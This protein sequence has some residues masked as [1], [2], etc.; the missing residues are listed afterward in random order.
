MLK[1]IK[2]WSLVAVGAIVS[3]GAASA[4]SVTFDTWTDT[5]SP[6]SAP[7]VVITE[8]AANKFSVSYGAAAGATS[9]SSAIGLY[10]FVTGADPM[11]IA[12]SNFLL[13]PNDP[14]DS[15]TP[16]KVTPADALMGFGNM[17]GSAFP[18]ASDWTFAILLDK[19]DDIGAEHSL[20]FDLENTI[21]TVELSDFARLGVRA[22]RQGSI[23]DDDRPG[24][25]K[26][27]G[28]ATPPSVVPLPAAGWMLIAGVAGLGAMRRR[29]KS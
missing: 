16:I 2:I 27:I 22:Q 12:A 4:A 25:D 13:D 21:G 18:D 11:G 6:S 17:N 5:D 14:F 28:F 8:T 1:S 3:A 10:F 9:V 24:S 20:T 19:F 29:K 26:L 7:V 15:T 23:N